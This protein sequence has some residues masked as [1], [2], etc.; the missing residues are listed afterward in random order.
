MIIPDEIITAESRDE[1]LRL[2][3]EAEAAWD[4]KKNHS[5]T[6]DVPAPASVEVAVR[7]DIELAA[8]P[9]GALVAVCANSREEY[10]ELLRAAGLGQH[11]NDGVQFAFND[12]GNRIAS[13]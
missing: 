5:C 13:K 11:I 1:E 8:S 12:R 10:E 3:R 7:H 9:A 6:V 4:V 2:K